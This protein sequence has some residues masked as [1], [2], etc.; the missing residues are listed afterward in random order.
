M[1]DEKGVATALLES[2]VG[3]LVTT[4]KV[5]EGDTIPYNGAKVSLIDASTMTLNKP[6]VGD[7]MGES[8][9]VTIGNNIENEAVQV[10]S[11]GGVGYVS[12][13]ILNAQ[14]AA[15]NMTGGRGGRGGRGGGGA[16]GGGFGGAG[17]GGFGGTGGGGFGGAG[18]G[19]FGGGGRGG[20]GFGGGPGAAAGGAGPIGITGTINLNNNPAINSIVNPA[21]DPPLPPGTIDNLEARMAARRAAQVGSGN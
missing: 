7:Q 15:N 21:L 5:H 18:G 20:G 3:G 17:G 1:K 11:V 13:D 19:G 9:I 10:S 6:S 12:A 14:T 4:F 8:V 16:G 2:S